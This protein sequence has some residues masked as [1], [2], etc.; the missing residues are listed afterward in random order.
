MNPQMM[1]LLGRKAAT[2]CGLFALP[3]LPQQEPRLGGWLPRELQPAADLPD[4]FDTFACELLP[5][6][7]AHYVPFVTDFV[8][9]LTSA[10]LSA[11]S[12]R[13]LT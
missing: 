5:E 6:D 1:R 2:G 7:E 13:F 11:S 10:F 8:G 12:T 9:S 3:H 4:P